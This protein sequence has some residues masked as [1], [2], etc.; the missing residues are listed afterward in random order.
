MR[1]RL[2][3]AS[4][5]TLAS[6]T[7]L[8]QRVTAPVEIGTCTFSGKGD[9][10]DSWGKRYLSLG[11]D[12][13]ESAQLRKEIVATLSPPPCLLNFQRP[14]FIVFSI[15]GAAQ[16]DQ[17][18]T[19]VR[20]VVWGTDD[21]VYLTN[22]RGIDELREVFVTPE[23]SRAPN[24]VLNSIYT[25]TPVEDPRGAELAAALKQLG[26]TLFTQLGPTLEA[27]RVGAPL[28]MTT[29]RVSVR[30]VV[31]PYA[32]AKIGVKSQ[33]FAEVTTGSTK[34]VASAEAT[35]DNAAPNHVGFSLIGAGIIRVAGARRAKI[36]SGTIIENS[37]DGA[38]SIIAMNI[39]PWSYDPTELPIS[40]GERWRLFLGIV[41][42]PELGIA[43]GGGWAPFRNLSV[44]AGYAWLRVKTTKGG[45]T[46]GVSPPE[47]DTNP[48]RHGAARAFVFGV[49]YK[50]S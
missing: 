50:F 29:Y 18:R 35:Y 19:L 37:F 48:L 11:T 47:G 23:R 7:A 40:A 4:L 46:I 27:A 15:P 49:G 13:S 41:A 2:L 31:I 24:D 39:H 22:L 21:P 26:P 43:V 17:P 30:R 10:L 28:G 6:A 9:L 14:H 36:D 33:L 8:A 5:L 38:A 45:E 3:G 32:R 42:T 20:L 1:K 44:N 25:S 12:A 34:P 16:K